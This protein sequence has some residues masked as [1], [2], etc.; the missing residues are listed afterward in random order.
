VEK[1]NSVMKTSSMLGSFRD[2]PATRTEFL[3]LIKD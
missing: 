2:N 1:Q 3:S